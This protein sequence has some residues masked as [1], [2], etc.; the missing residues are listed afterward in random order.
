MFEGIFKTSFEDRKLKRT[1]MTYSVVLVL[2]QN[3][4]NKVE[5]KSIL[6][7]KGKKIIICRDRNFYTHHSYPKKRPKQNEKN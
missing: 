3:N 5:R 4:N 7:Q 6:N 2:K 1:T